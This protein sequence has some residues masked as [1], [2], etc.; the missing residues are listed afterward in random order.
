MLECVKHERH[1]KLPM[2]AP[3]AVHVINPF[4]TLTLL[5]KTKQCKEFGNQNTLIT[6]TCNFMDYVT[7]PFCGRDVAIQKKSQADQ[8]S[9]SSCALRSPGGGLWGSF[10]VPQVL[11]FLGSLMHLSQLQDQEENTSLLTGPFKLH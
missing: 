10:R 9:H 2:D 5:F 8:H 4:N 1:C 3:G 7:S 6:N 11:L